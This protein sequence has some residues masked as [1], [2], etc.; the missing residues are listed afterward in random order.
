MD[1]NSRGYKRWLAYILGLAIVFLVIA[2][3]TAFAF[4]P[5]PGDPFPIWLLVVVVGV[6]VTSFSSALEYARSWRVQKKRLSRNEPI[7]QLDPFTAWL[8]TFFSRKRK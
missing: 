1:K 7:D 2:I 6:V 4:P 8:I 5:R 3:Y